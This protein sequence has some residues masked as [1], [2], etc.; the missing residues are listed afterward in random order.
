[1]QPHLKSLRKN[2]FSHG[3]QGMQVGLDSEL[4]RETVPCLQFVD[5]CTMLAPNRK[6]L[7]ELFRRYVNF[8]SK[9]RVLVNWGKCSVTVFRPT[10]ILSSEQKAEQKALKKAA[11]ACLASL[12]RAQAKDLLRAEAQQNE[13]DSPSYLAISS[14][15][16]VKQSSRCRV[17]GAHLH[18]HL[19][20]EGAKLHVTSK[21]Y[22][23]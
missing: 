19:G 8:C 21:V 1:M 16:S 22:R 6:Q 7:V 15:G 5:D 10:P 18:E 2:F 3:F 13:A 20:A 12:P 11:A 17:L 14:G 9:L 23:K 4:L